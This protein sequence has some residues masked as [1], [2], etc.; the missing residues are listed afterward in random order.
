MHINNSYN[1]NNSSNTGI[2]KGN[3]KSMLYFIGH[4][5]SQFFYS[6]WFMCVCV[7]VSKAQMLKSPE[8]L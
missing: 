4:R 8:K 5:I 3:K 1:N 7:F 6:E 2:E